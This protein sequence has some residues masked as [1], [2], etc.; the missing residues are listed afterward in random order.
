MT[1]KLTTFVIDNKPFTI[2]F[3]ET[4]TVKEGVECD[5][6]ALTDDDTKDLAIVRVQKG[7]KTPLQRILL[8]N[9]TIEGFVGGQGALSVQSIDGGVKT[10]EFKSGDAD[11]PIVVEIGQIMQ[12]YANGDTDLTFYEVCEPPYK[13]GRFENLPEEHNE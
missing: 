2:S 4:Q 11:R 10:Y 1:S 7:Y 6:Y 3:G 12:W 8:G 9:K 5:T 13:D